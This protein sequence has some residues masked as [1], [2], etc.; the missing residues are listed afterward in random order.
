[1]RTID[2]SRPW[3]WVEKAAIRKI[4]EA[5]DGT[6]NVS[7]ALAVYYALAEVASDK[8]NEKFQTTY[9]WLAT[10]SGFSQRTVGKRISELEAIGLMKVTIPPLRAPATYEILQIGNGCRAIRNDCS[11]LSNGCPALGNGQLPPLPT[12]E[13]QKKEES[14]ASRSEMVADQE[15]PLAKV[16]RQI[17]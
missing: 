6:H 9:A 3:S 1:V 5:F 17:I 13:E 16:R 8:A 11:T 14:D 4:R 7:S 12:S 10:L 2:A 15:S